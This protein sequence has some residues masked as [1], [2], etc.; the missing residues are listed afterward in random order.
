MTGKGMYD[1]PQ[2]FQSLGIS[3]TTG[4]G[5]GGLKLRRAAWTRGRTLK[6][7]AVQGDEGG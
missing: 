2:V 3:R 4:S 7:A 6:G 5:Q 1:M